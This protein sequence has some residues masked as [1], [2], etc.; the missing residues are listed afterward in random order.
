M[1]AALMLVTALAASGCFAE[2]SGPSA[3][4]PS[5]STSAASAAPTPLP[6]GVP[7]SALPK[8]STAS[9]P[10]ATARPTT[11]DPFENYRWSQATIAVGQDTLV[12]ALSDSPFGLIA[13]GVNLAFPSIDATF[14]PS[15]DPFSSWY[16]VVV[17]T[18]PDG[19][20]WTQESDSAQFG[21][22]RPTAIVSLDSTVLMF[23]IGGLCLPDACSGL[24]PNGGTIV[25][26]SSD[27]HAWQRL[28]GTGLENGAVSGVAGVDGGL[29]AVGYVADDGSKP[30]TDEF[31]NP[32]DAAVW[33][34]TDGAHWDLVR[35]LPVADAL[36]SIRSF[37]SNLIAI[38]SKGSDSLIVWTSDDG[39]KSWSEGDAVSDYW[40]SVA[41][42]PDGRIVVVTDTNA[43]SIDGV[44][45]ARPELIGGSW[46]HLQPTVMNGYR[47]VQVVWAGES[48]VTFGWTAHRDGALAVDDA[49][50]AFESADGLDWSPTVVPPGWEGQAP[51]SV[52][53]HAG[54]LVALLDNLDTVNETT[55]DIRHTIWTGTELN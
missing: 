39:G 43:D 16:S 27:G 24:P 44:V 17:W 50:R 26:S 13:A 37:G 29:V 9:S 30:D 53:D 8:P 36:S 7:A 38:G 1:F 52:I 48:F 11:A 41:V 49:Q 5:L 12:S 21:G 19:R 3:T 55:G 33:R 6:T 35:G 25:W 32:T 42:A 10:S 47:P 45:Y 46:K 22:G 23:G 20:T 54:D 28:G 2:P 4:P 14:A 40:R 15:Q 34:S 31:S 18:S 51:V